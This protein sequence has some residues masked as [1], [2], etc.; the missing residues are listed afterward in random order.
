MVASALATLGNCANIQSIIQILW[1]MNIIEVLLTHANSP[2]QHICIPALVL[3]GLLSID[4]NEGSI[5]M[6]GNQVSALHGALTDATS[7]TSL[8]T[9][10][11]YFRM[12]AMELLRGLN[13]LALNKKN[14]ILFVEN[15]ILPVLTKIL[16]VGNA[17]N[18][19]TAVEFLWTLALETNIRKEISTTILKVQEAPGSLFTTEPR[20]E[21]LILAAKC[22]L[23]QINGWNQ[24][25][26]TNVHMLL[27]HT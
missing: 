13:G 5:M 3:L 12:T 10:V 23:L 14:A 7:S 15:G 21:S 20:S 22:A 9:V 4:V 1:D 25:E 24:L 8:T 11:G 19:Q 2:V 18:K 16:S 27:F 17:S 6:N 26:G